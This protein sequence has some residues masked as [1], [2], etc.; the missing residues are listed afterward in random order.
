MFAV[1]EGKIGLSGHVCRHA[2]IVEDDAC[3]HHAADE[4]CQGAKANSSF[5]IALGATK[6]ANETND[7]GSA[8][9]WMEPN[10]VF[11]S[12]YLVA[13]SS[14]E[15]RGCQDAIG[16]HCSV[17]KK[18]PNF[19]TPD[20]SLDGIAFDDAADDWAVA[21]P[22]LVASG[23][24]QLIEDQVDTKREWK[25]FRR[26]ADLPQSRTVSFPI[27][28]AGPIGIHFRSTM[29][30]G[31]P[32]STE[33]NAGVTSEPIGVWIDFVDDG[34]RAQQAGIQHGERLVQ[35]N[36]KN[37]RNATLSEAVAMVRKT[38]QSSSAASL[39]LCLEAA[40]VQWHRGGDLLLSHLSGF[41]P[42]V[43]DLSPN[44]HE[45]APGLVE[46]DEMEDLDEI[47][48]ASTAFQDMQI[49]DARGR[50]LEGRA[51]SSPRTNDKTLEQLSEEEVQGLFVLF[52][53]KLRTRGVDVP[54]DRA[55]QLFD[56]K[57]LSTPFPGKPLPPWRGSY[58][59]SKSLS[60]LGFAP[61]IHDPAEA[62]SQLLLSTG[63]GRYWAIVERQ[64]I[65][66]ARNMFQRR[67]QAKNSRRNTNGGFVRTTERRSEDFI[68][69]NL[70][71]QISEVDGS[72][73]MALASHL[74][75]SPHPLMIRFSVS[76][77]PN[78]VQGGKNLN[79]DLEIS[80]CTPA[81]PHD[82]TF[83]S[84]NNWD[85]DDDDEEEDGSG[86]DN[87]SEPDDAN[88]QPNMIR[89]ILY[90]EGPG[91]GRLSAEEDRWVRENGGLNVW[92]R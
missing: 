54:E 29:L 47:T 43:Y 20:V 82:D 75:G 74:S 13:C 34:S 88:R 38:L 92:L 90:R 71:G 4:E 85:F 70:S 68:W 57:L 83:E 67:L 89:H 33:K 91:W 80:T 36:G 73:P 37:V 21:D 62:V 56:K 5:S 9:A 18:I 52:Q 48:L 86:D 87:N 16:Q 66:W 30:P 39:D 59:F 15:P 23:K 65:V 41:Y 72:T 6:F 1:V 50:V 44:A 76:T 32:L 14:L 17:S 58:S 51:Y 60:E 69:D 7:D 11:D 10:S 84:D 31:S 27:P 45:S 77:V 12:L 25:L 63:N 46:D 8:S 3:D 40:T 42:A 61:G 28:A 53:Q 49:D 81:S 78:H 64:A 79:I 26:A 35:V 22:A 19:H 55:R 2:L 24:V